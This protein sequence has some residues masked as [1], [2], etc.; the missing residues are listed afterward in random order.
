MSLPA[1][2]GPAWSVGDSL[3]RVRAALTG[4]V[5]SVRQLGDGSLLANCVNPG[6]PDRHPS[7]HISH[8][9]TEH[10]GRTLFHCASCEQAC[11]QEDYANWCGLEA[12][13]LFDDRRWNLRHPDG[14]AGPGRRKPVRQRRTG[15]TFGRLG[16]L[17]K[18]IATD[19][20]G[21]LG[22]PGPQPELAPSSGHE[23]DWV[24]VETYDYLDAGGKPF[25]RVHRHKC[26][27]PGCGAKNFPQEYLTPGADP[28]RQAHWFSTQK[29]AGIGASWSTRL[30]RQAEVEAAVA[31]GRDV[32]ILEGEKD[33]HTAEAAGLVATTNP[34]GGRNF[35]AHLAEPLA[36]AARVNCVHD[37]D[38]TGYARAVR[39]EE[40]L[41]GVQ[42]GQ[43]RHYLPATEAAKSDFT[44]HIQA[45]HDV[46]GLLELPIAA[47]Q[48]WHQLGTKVTPAET[49]IETCLEEVHARLRLAEHERKQGRKAAAGDNR[50][51]ATRWAKEA[52]RAH[53]RLVDGAQAIAAITDQITDPAGRAWAEQALEIAETRLRTLTGIVAGL[54]EQVGQ[55]VPPEV[56]AAAI[57]RA[58]PVTASAQP[59]RPGPALHEDAA[60]P[61]LEPGRPTFAV[62]P[63]GGGGGGLAG[64]RIEHDEFA[65]VG[66]EL[67]QVFWKSAGAEATRTYKRVINVPI[68]LHAK[69]MAESEE[70]IDLE[71][72]DL[73]ALGDRQG[74]GATA[75]VSNLTAMT[76]V[77]LTVPAPD[78]S[79]ALV[80]IPHEEYEDG[81]F[82]AHL[83][84]PH[85]NYARSRAGRDKVITAINYVSPHTEIRTSYR[86]TG[87]RR[88]PDGSSIYLTAA[89]AIGAKGFLDVPTN[90]GGA[91]ARF[92]LPNPSDEAARIRQAFT[93]GAAPLVEQFPDRVGAVLVGQAFR[94]AIAPNEWVTVLSASPGAGKTGLASL[95]M[96]FF[97]EMWDRNRSVSSMSGNGA[98]AN[99]LRIYAHQAKD[100]VLF[101]DDNAP[102]NGA[103]QAW[104]RLETTIRMIHNQEGRGR[105]TRNGQGTLPESR[106]R[107]S[108]LITTEL[109]PR[110]GSS[111]GRRALVVPMDRHEIDIG[112]IIDL[113]AMDARH[114][115]ALVMSSFLRWVAADH[116]GSLLRAKHLR[117]EY[118]A[119]VKAGAT[120][121]NRKAIEEHGVKVAE[122]WAGWGLLLDFLLDVGALTGPEQAAWAD[123]VQQA[124]LVAAESAD[125][126]D[127]VDSTGS[128]ACELLRYALTNGIAYAA[129][130]ATGKAPPFLERRLG[131]REQGLAE[132]GDPSSSWKPD[133]R[134]ILLGHVNRGPDGPDPDPELLC[135]KAALAAVLKAAAAQ[136]PDTSALDPGTVLRALEEE[137]VLKVR[138]EL[139]PGG[140][141][142]RRTLDRTIGCLTSVSDP[143]KPL[144][145][146]RIVLR[147]PALFGEDLPERGQPPTSPPGAGPDQPTTPGQGTG[148]NAGENQPP[149]PTEDT[150]PWGTD[151]EEEQMQAPPATPTEH[152]NAGGLTLPKTS[153]LDTRPCARCGQRCSVEL[154]GL[155][156]HLPC[157]WATHAATLEQLHAEIQTRT[158][159]AGTAT[160]GVGMPDE[161]TPAADTAPAGAAR[162]T[163][164]PATASPFRAAAAVIDV[165][166]AWLPDGTGLQL[167]YRI[168]HL[169]HLEQLGRDLGLGAPPV[170]WHDWPEAGIVV[171]TRALWASLGVEVDKLPGLPSKRADWLKKASKGLPALTD[172]AAAGWVF[173]RGDTDPVLRGCIRLRRAGQDRG[174]IR[175]LMNAGFPD[176]W[177]ITEPVADP[178]T[179]V[180]RLQL[181]T[182]LVGIPFA[183]GGS[184]I[185]T[186][187]DLF[188]AVTPVGTRRKLA[189]VDWEAVPPAFL[190]TLEEHFD[191]TRTPSRDEL[192]K[193]HLML[194][195]RGQSYLA[196]WSRLPVGLG[197]PTHLAGPVTFNPRQPGWWRITV[198]DPRLDGHQ[199]RQPFPDL[200]DPH[201][202]SAGQQRWVTTPALAYAIEH[203]EATVAISEAWVW[204]PERSARALEKFYG[205]IR[206]ALKQLDQQP[207]PDARAV[208]VMVKTVYKQFS[209]YFTSDHAAAAKSELHQPYWFHAT[210]AQARVAILHQILATGGGIHGAGPWPLVVANNDLIGYAVDQLG[211]TGWPG[212]PAKLGRTPGAYKPAR[213]APL[214]EHATYLTGQQWHGLEATTDYHPSDPEQA[215]PGERQ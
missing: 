135:D 212:N 69:E 179:I 58:D 186:A 204:P 59:A 109:P 47:F 159:T 20:P 100:A 146:K 149:I 137:G 49:T 162:P 200:L 17:P 136:M 14:R 75:R 129:D 110:A 102:T 57:T 203:L 141:V 45:G 180:R 78:G 51:Y 195:D 139:R 151:P 214:P 158:T 73:A 215:Q 88:Q 114:D 169:G 189:P 126:P 83:P 13:D 28:A 84:V 82:L 96:H 56:T 132:P 43:V 161:P 153:H 6:H 117:D 130:A 120:S 198:P 60:D 164:T 157:F 106:P 142:T 191:W 2:T 103:T 124:L 62:I 41:R 52:S 1:S 42:A 55:I 87:W 205:V 4:R 48:A 27:T 166:R 174:Q 115:R 7:M 23:H 121:A 26:R 125:D 143:G 91:M 144:R 24:A 111:G 18:P 163:R 97:G 107:T 39:L 50:R 68:T 66:D 93:R 79:Q 21:L 38:E 40:L 5:A 89:G 183:A 15:A 199:M 53:A 150:D 85:L 54:F 131:W 71:N 182:E 196:T 98:T 127:L 72:I 101:L 208:E 94:A 16:P 145:E 167:P 25:H 29:R 90:L 148:H 176:E 36:G 30:Y 70:D 178:A 206:L 81:S 61:G 190:R 122:I 86:A 165:D 76:H 37:R 22:Q 152:T 156:L 211:D 8:V 155:P 44:D 104:E 112:R 10:G 175:I 210:I 3:E 116:Q 34:G 67:T 35:A 9:V 77:V 202:T 105:A 154:G 173:G 80:R 108:G 64:V 74:R 160:A 181:F 31:A 172:A 201:G 213:H 193:A 177:G 33:V 46:T 99:A 192:A 194:W 19:L 184:P 63:G 32:W 123:R 168:E 188:E 197:A 128:R 133:P 65:I 209:G 12:D 113:D 147:L 118:A 119:A 134:G 92:D 95:A 171:P 140:S 138:H 11:S 187:I 207:G 170:G 185:S